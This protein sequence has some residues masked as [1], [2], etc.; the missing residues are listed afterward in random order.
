MEMILLCLFGCFVLEA[1]SP[2]LLLVELILPAPV[3]GLMGPPSE[4]MGV[5]VRF[6][7]FPSSESLEL[8]D[9]E[10]LEDSSDEELLEDCFDK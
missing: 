6:S 8:D 10:L 7:Q 3:P 4:L 2:V 9:N 1:S 5:P